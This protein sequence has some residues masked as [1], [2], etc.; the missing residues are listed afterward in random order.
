MRQP[1]FVFVS[2]LVSFAFSAWAQIS[3]DT[4]AIRGTVTDPQAR[5]VPG[6]TVVL[7]NAALSFRRETKTEIDG[8]YLFGL[9]PPAKDYQVDIEAAGFQRGLITNL[10]IEVTE[11]TNSSFELSLAT[12]TQDVL[13]AS[14]IEQVRTTSPALGGVVT[15][16]VIR[17]LPLNTRN[18]LQL[19]GTDAGVISAPGSTTL[20]VAGARSTYNNYVLNG[21]DANNFEQNSLNW[22]QMIPNPDSVQE[23]RT[24]TNLYDATMGRGGGATISLITR[25]GTNQIHGVAYDF[26]RPSVVSANDFFANRFGSPR[27]FFNRDTFGGSIGGPFPGRKTFW[28]ASYEGSRQRNPV[29]FSSSLP[30]L[31]PQR[32]ADTLASAF[33][34]PPRAIDPVAVRILNLS[35]PYNG[36]Y[37]PSGSG[38][39]VGTLGRFFTSGTS[40]LDQDQGSA[41]VDRDWQLG[42]HANR[43][44]AFLFFSRWDSFNPLGESPS[45][46]GTGQAFHYTSRGYTL[47]DIHVFSPKMINELTLGLTLDVTDGNNTIGE[48]HL[49]NVGMA[50]F[51]QSYLDGLPALTFNDQTGVGPDP[52]S[53]PRQHNDS[54]TFRDLISYNHGKHSLR[55]GFEHRKYQFNQEQAYN[56]RGVLSFSSFNVADQFYGRPAPRADLAIRDFLIGAPSRTWVTSGVTGLGFRA[57]DLVGFG[58]DDYR[59]TRRLTLNLGLRYDYLAPVT[60]HHHRLGTFDPGLVPAAARL[61]G[62]AGLLQGFVLPASLP[63]FG[64]PGVG[65]SL[66]LADD[67]KSFAP[68]AGFAYDVFGNARLA[69]RGGFGMYFNRGAALPALQLVSQPPFGISAIASGFLGAGVLANPFPSL[70]TRNELPAFPAMP[71]ITGFSPNGTP[72]FSAPQLR[73]FALDRRLHTPY[74]EQWNLTVQYQFR[75]GWTAEVGYLG[76]HGIRLLNDLSGNNALLRNENNPGALGLSSNSSFNRD[77]RVP[78]VGFGAAGIEMLNSTGRSFYDAGV[79]TISHQ[80]ARGLYL[81]AA[82]TFSKSLDNDSAAP[83]F[84]YGGVGGNQFLYDMNKGPSKF[85]A[86]H[87]VKITYLYELPGPRRGILST[88]AGGWAMSGI[89]TYLSGRPFAIAQGIGDTSLSGTAGRANLVAGCDMFVPGDIRDNLNHYLNPACAQVT[90]LLTGG[91]TFGPIAPTE[92]AGDQFYTITPGGGGRLQGTSGRNIFRGPPLSQWD[93]TLMKRFRLP[94]LGDSAR[95]ELRGEA[96]N[97]LNHASF[98]FPNSSAGSPTFGWIFGTTTIPRQ[99]EFALKLYF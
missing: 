85:D 5:A 42:G 53:G 61:N 90:P 62:G 77:A 44:S 76:T 45:G 16:E 86:T 19:L 31:P 29:L 82:Y 14:E 72:I 64:T 98:D 1:G 93:V 43:V 73:I 96:F 88:F 71:S 69:V 47:N 15:S 99:V 2:G 12:Q 33:N 48:Q 81:K 40:P 25:S 34:L 52:N 65:D 41:K 4:G 75:P 22:V 8:V 78:V 30:V 59:V 63:G 32:D 89:V 37:W 54:F 39:P 92:G 35:G 50:R 17:A 51:N 27:V 94:P 36:F 10:M 46:L 20:F 55:I 74:I 97:L 6:A 83:D 11:I 67:K 79:L 91:S 13:V 24:Q 21:M 3:P 26:L 66:L 9:V 56:E 60:E 23:F 7:S 68:R 58:Q 18:T 28:F 84:E 87:V 80:L 57:F 95:L 49:G 70:P 38:A